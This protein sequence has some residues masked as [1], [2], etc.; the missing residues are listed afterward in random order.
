MLNLQTLV[1]NADHRPLSYHPLSLWSWQDALTAVLLD[2]VN[3]VTSYD[4]EARSPSV[5]LPIPSVVALKTYL[6]VDRQPA[7][8]RYNIYVRDGK[9]CQYCSKRLQ[10]DELTFDHVIPRSR[11]GASSW[12]NVVAAC[13]T[14][15]MRKSNRTP[16]EAGMPLLRQPERPTLRELNRHRPEI[17]RKELHH[18]WI[19]FV[20]WDSELDPD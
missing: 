3:L 9:T 4:V 16:Q 2:R 14:C 6:D 18:S 5:R 13:P 20:Y 12:E 1:L 7:F 19:D 11:G 8:T 10:A 15:N 17:S